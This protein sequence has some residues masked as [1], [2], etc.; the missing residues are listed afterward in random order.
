[1]EEKVYYVY[2]MM[3]QRNTVLYIGITSDLSKR[4]WDH[5]QKIVPGF[6]QR[7]NID[8]LVYYEM[9][10]ESMLAIEREKQ[11]KRWRREKKLWL[12][13]K[14]NPTRRDLSDTL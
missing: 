3:N 4:I 6:T 10:N 12:I 5:K 8:K 7:Y 1:M 13:Q 11:L 2:M 9:Y 14:E